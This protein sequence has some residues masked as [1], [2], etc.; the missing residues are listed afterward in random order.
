MQKSLH[1]MQEKNTHNIYPKYWDTQARANSVDKAQMLQN[2]C[3]ATDKSGYSHIFLI[4]E[5]KHM[6]WVL[7]RSASA[8][9]F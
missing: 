1:D 8:R 3:I 5:W 2:D 7:I 6:L 9:R 4:S